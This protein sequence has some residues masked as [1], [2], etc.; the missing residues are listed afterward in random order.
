MYHLLYYRLWFVRDGTPALFTGNLEHSLGLPMSHISRED[1]MYQFLAPTTSDLTPADL[2]WSEI[3]QGIV[4]WPC[5]VRWAYI[6][7]LDFFT[8]LEVLGVEAEI[9]TELTTFVNIVS[10]ENHY[11]E[12]Y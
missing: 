2:H 9:Q 4:Y 3:L 11:V 8:V 6:R 10:N 5:E 7:F 12:I 1:K